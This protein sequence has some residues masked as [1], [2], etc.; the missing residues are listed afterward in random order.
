MSLGDNTEG[1]LLTPFK[2]HARKLPA[3]ISVGCS[4][5]YFLFCKSSTVR[6]NSEAPQFAL[7]GRASLSVEILEQDLAFLDTILV[8]KLTLF[9]VE[10]CSDRDKP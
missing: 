5:F 6:Q 8:F 2:L 1:S 3:C 10:R 7:E 9:L 4:L